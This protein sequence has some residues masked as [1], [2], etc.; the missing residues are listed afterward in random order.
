MKSFFGFAILKREG[1]SRLSL[2]AVRKEL[3]NVD[4]ALRHF[5]AHVD[6]A[7]AH[8]KLSRGS[9]HFL[10]DL[11]YG[12]ARGTA[13]SLGNR[14]VQRAT[15]VASIATLLI[16]AQEE[17]SARR[18]RLRFRMLTTTPDMGLTDFDEPELKL[19]AIRRH[20]YA[21]ARRAGVYALGFL[22]IAV[23]DEKLTLEPLKIAVHMHG[24]MLAVDN[25]FRT[26][27]AEDMASPVGNWLN[28]CGLRIV[29]I[30]S[31]KKDWGLPL[32]R[33][34]VAHL[35]YYIAKMSCGFDQ[36]F[37]KWGKRRTQTTLRGWKL[38]H[39][40]R[41]IECYSHC[42]ALETSCGTGRVGS[43]LRRRWKGLTLRLLQF[44]GAARALSIDHKT[45]ERS[46]TKLR[47]DLGQRTM[48]AVRVT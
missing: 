20:F 40:L 7:L 22:D 2:Q 46:W 4:K 18:L 30:T 24:A 35:G 38:E 48:R 13:L 44:D 12:D 34:I 8:P 27:R 17:P 23:V 28:K 9:R 37:T 25:S 26:K 29:K 16:H 42:D 15:M 19:R 36:L 1:L 3:H 10:R 14:A 33:A 31:K 43:Q 11:W 45:L 39:A 47:S 6:A 32:T 5:D 41:Q 21:A